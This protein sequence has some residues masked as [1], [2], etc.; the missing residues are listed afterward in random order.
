MPATW[1]C[2]VVWKLHAP[3]T[4]VQPASVVHDWPAGLLHKPGVGE[5]FPAELQD[6]PDGVTQV[7]GVLAHT[8]PGLQGPPLVLHRP[9]DGKQAADEVQGVLTGVMHWPVIA[10]QSLFTLQAAPPT[11]QWPLLGV[12]VQSPAEV[13]DWPEGVTQTPGV[14]VHWAAVV[15]D[16]PAGLLHVPGVLWQTVFC[17]AAVHTV[18][19][20]ATQW[21][22]ATQGLVVPLQ[23][24]PVRLHVPPRT[25]QFPG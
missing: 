9:G 7:P 17:V 16:W 1:H 10:G 5:Q 13:Q 23:A 24:A 3:T 12:P 14:A 8:G 6:W 2:W 21:P 18:P 11:V 4:L 20:G 15:Q 22:A 19:A 25:A